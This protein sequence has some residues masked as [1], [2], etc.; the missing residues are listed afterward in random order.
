MI[1]NYILDTL[2]EIWQKLQPNGCVYIAGYKLNDH[3]LL[4]KL[5]PDS[6]PMGNGWEQLTQAMPK[7]KALQRLDH[8]RLIKLVEPKNSSEIGT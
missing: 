1:L 3:Y 4:M 6:M 7:D 5:V 2:W 8:F